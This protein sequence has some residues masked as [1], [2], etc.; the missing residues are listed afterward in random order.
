MKPQAQRI[1]NWYTDFTGGSPIFSGSQ[2]QTGSLF[3]DTTFY[4]SN[5]DETYESLRKQTSI[6]INPNPSAE[7][8]VSPESSLPGETLTF[9]AI[10]T[11]GATWL[12]DFGDGITSTVQN[13]VHS[14]EHGG[15]YEVILTVTSSDGCKTTAKKALGIITG[16]ENLSNGKLEI[17]PNPITTERVQLT[18]SE[19][20][21]DVELRLFTSH[22]VLVRT[23]SLQAGQQ[24][25]DVSTLPNGIYILR[26]GD[27]SNVTTRKVVISR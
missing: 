7:F 12:W 23:E 2:F 16:L 4:V 18:V 17:Y 5:A 20:S 14:Y 10:G 15:E 3:S 6:T 9:S 1:F 11:N 19:P 21:G 13:P 26:I 27:S 24:S 8:T 22:G 25:F